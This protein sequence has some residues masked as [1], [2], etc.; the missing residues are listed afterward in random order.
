MANEVPTGDV[1][2]GQFNPQDPSG[3]PALP[4]ARPGEAPQSPVQPQPPAAGQPSAPAPARPA[5][6][7]PKP[8]ADQHNWFGKILEGMAGQTKVLTTD[9]KTGQSTYVAQPMT[10]GAIAR[11]ILAGAISG[12]MAGYEHQYS[13]DSQGRLRQNLG[14]ATAAGA[15]AGEAQRQKPSQVA[16]AIE[17]QKNARYYSTVKQNQELYSAAMHNT[18]LQ[19]EIMQKPV[20]ENKGLLTQLNQWQASHP[21]TQIV[22]QKNG[23]PLQGVP[24]DQIVKNPDLVDLMR[25]GGIIDGTAPVIDEN[26]Q[27]KMMEDGKTPMMQYTYTIID[28]NAMFK[29]N[30]AMKDEIAKIDP[31]FKDVSPNATV[32]ARMFPNP[33]SRSFTSL[34][35][36][37]IN[38]TRRSAAVTSPDNAAG[39]FTCLTGGSTRAWFDVEKL[40]EPSTL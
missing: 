25:H 39:R 27:P 3:V 10:K 38:L 14:E 24:G 29:L 23:Q 35:F 21:E 16:Q 28:P 15:E 20:D 4:V 13:R 9:P 22:I 32:S 40:G 7:P 1:S 8:V 19:G 30:P 18:Q 37:Q 31:R 5:A 36:S 11:G 26:G 33:S 2:Q 6:Q 17:D 12:M 34:L